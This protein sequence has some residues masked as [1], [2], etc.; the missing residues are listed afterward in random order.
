MTRPV[1]VNPAAIARALPPAP[2]GGNGGF[3]DTP[4]TGANIQ[5]PLIAS[6]DQWSYGRTSGTGLPR[7]PNTFL[8]GS[9]GPLMPMQPIAIDQPNPDTG[10]PDVRRFQYPVSWNIPHGVPGDDGLKLASFVNLRAIGDTYSVARACIQLRKNELIGQGWDIV[11]TKAAEKAMRGD[12]AARKEFEDRRAKLMRFF[13]RPDTNY[14]AFRDWFSVLLDDVLV[15]DALSIYMWPSRRPGKGVMGS[16]LGEL[17][18]VDGSTI[19]PLVDVHGAIPKAPQPGY[20]Q[21]LF[22]VPRTDLMTA[23]SGEDVADMGDAMTQQYRGD[24]LIYRPQ[25]PRDWTVYGFA[26]IEQALVPIL[27]G[28]QRQQWQLDAYSERSIPGLFVSCGDPNATPNQIR[29]LQDALNAMAGDPAWQHKIIVL[30]ANSKIDPQRPIELAGTFDEIIMTQTCMAFSVMPM[31]LGISPRSSTSGHSGGAANQMGKMSSDTQERK[32]NR[33]M[34][35]WFSDIF[36]H[37]IRDVC[38]QHDMQWWWE[39]LEE[40]EDERTKTDIQTA[41]VAIG[42]MSIDEARTENGDQ[43]WGLPTTSDPVLIT[44]TG[45]VPFGSIDPQT[46]QPEGLTPKLTA[47]PPPPGTF[48]GP[49]QQPPSGGGGGTPAKPT[50]PK[51]KPKPAGP[52][53]GQSA[54]TPAHAAGQQQTANKPAAKPAAAATAAKPAAEKTVN[55]FAALRE[56]D[57]IRRRINKGRTLDGWVPEHIPTDLFSVLVDNPVPGSVDTARTVVKTIAHRQRRDQATA[58]AQRHIVDGLRDLAAGLAAGTVSTATFVD[59]AVGVL[60]HGI[61]EG[62]AAGAD[63]AHGT[64]VV[65]AADPQ[66]IAD[67]RYQLYAGQAVQAYEV[68]YGLVTLGSADDPD[69]IAVLWHPRDGACDLCE[70]RAGVEY[71]VGTLPG[72]PGEGSFGEQCSGGPRCRCSLEY[73]RIDPDTV[74]PKPTSAPTPLQQQTAANVTAVRRALAGDDPDAALDDVWTEVAGQRAETQRPYL[75]GLLQDLQSAMTGTSAPVPV[76]AAAAEV[77]LPAAVAAS[78]A[79]AI[80]AQRDSQTEAAQVTK[81]AKKRAR[82]VYDYLARHYPADTL[83]W[84]KAAEWRGPVDVPLTDVSMA[85]RPGGAR[86]MDKV[87]SIAESIEAGETLDPVVLVETPGGPPYKVADGFHRTLALDRVGRRTVSAWIGKVDQDTGPW[88]KEMHEEKLNKADEGAVG[89]YRAR[90]LIRW[91]NEGADGQIPWGSGGDFEACRR[92]AAGHV[93]AHEIDGFCANRHHDALGIWPATHAAALR[94][95]G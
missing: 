85:R 95:K 21:Y 12:R 22:G 51:P 3:G 33:P 48:G 61:R 7:N 91:Y 40:D 78:T 13:R 9:F 28:I 42:L 39:G 58:D 46:G 53:G 34:L 81:G 67:S 89:D 76:A 52:G 1:A 73:R 55:T 27:S 31:E 83:D 2:T 69:N 25:N 79:L 35:E 65:K 37:V 30:P 63:H 71:T 36:N 41:K 82:K 19:R 94:R 70:A 75:T 80:S 8:A 87:Q 18:A 72:W 84:V 45:A 23:V 93:P 90:H 10:R 32:A 64:T 57:L 86:D 16:N 6:Y 43:P 62:L 14:F 74:P 26:P 66:P 59:R 29:E 17:A 44:P 56:L 20:Q 88:A 54:A 60:H 38:R 49:G 77:T 24:Q 15:I 92:V 50:K 47:A 68:G 5:S 4:F 11:P